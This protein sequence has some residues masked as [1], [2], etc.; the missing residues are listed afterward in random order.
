MNHLKR[1]YNNLFFIPD[2]FYYSFL[3]VSLVFS[4]EALYADLVRHQQ[5]WAGIFSRDTDV[6]KA[7]RIAE[8]VTALATIEFQRGNYGDSM[9]IMAKSS[10]ILIHMTEI[11][12]ER[13][14]AGSAATTFT[15]AD[16][17]SLSGTF[18]ASDC[19]NIPNYRESH[20]L[21][22]RLS[23]ENNEL[24]L[25]INLCGYKQHPSLFEATRKQVC[26]ALRRLMAWELDY[27]VSFK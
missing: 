11:M 22:N 26:F 19:A 1:L 25:N 4:L 23:F 3:Q 14:P 27:K 24:L 2:A 8:L 10:E 9:V 15:D 20:I 16:F 21:L 6:V 7:S 17:P 5:A 18:F 13:M 12:E